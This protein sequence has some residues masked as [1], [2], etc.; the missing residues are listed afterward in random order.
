[1]IDI[2][3]STVLNIAMRGNGLEVQF[4][5][6]V[7]DQPGGAGLPGLARNT[8]VGAFNTLA[9]LPVGV[10]KLVSG[11]TFS[12]TPRTGVLSGTR[13]ALHNIAHAGWVEKGPGRLLNA[14]PKAIVA[15]P[16]LIYGTGRDV[17]QVITGGGNR[18]VDVRAA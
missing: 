1:M 2:K 18:G 7:R 11:R 9:A 3:I 10:T 16:E 12:Q 5:T 15:I 13:T 17:M 6:V 14:I 4:D 8:A